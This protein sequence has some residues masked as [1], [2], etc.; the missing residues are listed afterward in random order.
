M[1]KQ[2]GFTLIELVITIA[3]IGI[4]SAIALPAYQG[5]VERAECEDGKALLTGAANFMERYRTQNNGSY[6]NASINNYGNSST[7]FSAAIDNLTASSYTL[8][9]N[10]TGAVRISGTMT[11]TE[12]NAHGGTLAGTCSW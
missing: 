6:S 12:A 7:T 3:I 11:L 2:T 1:T 5:Y 4:L 9:V 8:R 10:T